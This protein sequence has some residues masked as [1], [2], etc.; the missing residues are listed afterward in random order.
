M[1]THHSLDF[2]VDERIENRIDFGARYPK[3]VGD[4]LGFKGAD[5]KLGAGLLRLGAIA[6]DLRRSF[7]RL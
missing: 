5:N 6:G 7:C 4:T 3:N 1:P 2:G